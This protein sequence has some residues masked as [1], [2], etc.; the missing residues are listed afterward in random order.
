MNICFLA[1][2]RA[3]HTRRWAKYF[4][5]KGH[6]VTVITINP[7]TLDDFD[8]VRVR[9]VRKRFAGGDI[10]SRVA[11]LPGVV[12][13]VRQ[14]LKA[15]RTDILH[16]HSAG[17]YA[18][19]AMASG[20]HPFVI[21]PW[22]TD[23]LVDVKKSLGNR[24]LTTMALRRADLVT[25]DAYHMQNEMLAMGVHPNRVKLIIFGVDLRRFTARNPIEIA[26]LRRR[27]GLSAA[28]MVTSTRTLTPIHDVETFVRALPLILARHSDAQFV[29]VADGSSRSRIEALV[30]ELGVRSSVRFTGYVSEDVMAMWLKISDVY[31]STS[32]ADA[33]LAGS[34]AEAMAVEL[35]VVTTDNG[36]NRLWV[37]EGR[38]GF[39]VPNGDHA[40]IADRVIRLLDDSK[41]RAEFGKYNRG[42]IDE[43]NNYVTEMDR[44]EQLYM[45]LATRTPFEGR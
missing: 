21:T 43:R 9:I 13:D 19:L 15:S 6:S 29:I 20:F 30:D 33:G 18:W 45:Q 27:E 24:L 35:P 42:V 40:G 8:P 32:L 39:I 31:V 16:A 38:G 7:D 10:F 12:G 5:L 26:A 37:E 44:M 1:D 28:P 25:C 14:I 23:I 41:R 36:D 2:A 22:G 17:G 34:T 11:S 4:A 3:E